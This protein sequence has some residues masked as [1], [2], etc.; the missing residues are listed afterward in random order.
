MAGAAGGTLEDASSLTVCP[1]APFVVSKISATTATS[2]GDL[3]LP[4]VAMRRASVA[5]RGGHHRLAN[6]PE[7]SLRD[8]EVDIE[9]HA[10]MRALC[11]WLHAG[12]ASVA[13]HQ[14]SIF[15]TAAVGRIYGLV[16]Q[17]HRCRQPDVLTGRLRRQ[18]LGLAAR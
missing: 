7:P 3:A 5:G 18:P 2:Q 4:P 14:W 11:R 12:A 17:P 1:A 8:V 9:V 6:R 16:T 10:A 15:N 13:E